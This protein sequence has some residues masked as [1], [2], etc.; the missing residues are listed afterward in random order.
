MHTVIKGTKTVQE[1]KQVKV[2]MEM[3]TEKCFSKHKQASENW[4]NG[5]PVKTWWDSDGNLCIEY[6]SGNWWHY[7]NEG[8]WW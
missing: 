8:E 7:N 3:L 6:E 5:E 4:E 2:L 1:Y